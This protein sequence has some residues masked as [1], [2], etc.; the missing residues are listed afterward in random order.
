MSDQ[1]RMIASLSRKLKNASAEVRARG[2]VVRTAT[3]FLRSKGYAMEADIFEA[4]LKKPR[5]AAAM[6]RRIA[7]PGRG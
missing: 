7:P 1:D 2:N 5:K 4:A 6:T 3:T